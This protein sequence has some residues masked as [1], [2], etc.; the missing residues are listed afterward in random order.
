VALDVRVAPARGGQ[1]EALA[2]QLELLSAA[3]RGG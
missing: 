1:R 2:Q 3:R